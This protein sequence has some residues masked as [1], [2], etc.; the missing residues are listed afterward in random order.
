M[1]IS[2]SGD[3]WPALK[4]HRPQLASLFRRLR[5]PVQNA[6]CFGSGE[7]ILSYWGYR[8]LSV[9]SVF[10]VLLAFWAGCHLISYL[11]LRSMRERR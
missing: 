7:A 1:H 5:L 11:A 9:G 6:A 10:G 8:A 3:S 2:A 4:Q